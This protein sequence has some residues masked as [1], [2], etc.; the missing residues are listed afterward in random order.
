MRARRGVLLEAAGA[1]LHAVIVLGACALLCCSAPPRHVAPTSAACA[2]VQSSRLSGSVHGTDGFPA[3]AALLSIDGIVQRVAVT[4]RNG[5]FVVDELPP[6]RYLV[7]ARNAAA[8]TAEEVLVLPGGAEAQLWLEQGATTRLRVLD[9]ESGHPITGAVVR[10]G[11]WK[12]ETDGDGDALVVGALPGLSVIDVSA[13]AHASERVSVTLARGGPAEAAII[14]RLGRGRAVS[15]VVEGIGPLR[16]VLVSRSNTGGNSEVTIGP[17]GKWQARVRDDAT[18]VLEVSNSFGHTRKE[19]LSRASI[20]PRWSMDGQ[21]TKTIELSGVV[22]GEPVWVRVVTARDT[23]EQ[24]AEGPHVRLCGR[25]DG[26]GILELVGRRGRRRLEI[27]DGRLPASTELRDA[28]IAGSLVDLE[29]VPISG[30]WIEVSSTDSPVGQKL[31]THANRDGTFQ[32]PV[33]SG[34]IY[35]IRA[36]YPG[37]SRDRQFSELRVTS[38]DRLKLVVPVPGSIR[39]RLIL[40]GLPVSS[41]AVAVSRPTLGMLGRP[42]VSRVVNTRGAFE[43][44]GLEPGPWTLIV[45]GPGFAR[46][47]R[48]IDV[49]SGV[50]DLGDLEVD[51]GLTLRGQVRTADGPNANATV[52]VRPRDAV[53]SY[54][55]WTDPAVARLHGIATTRTDTSGQFMIDIDDRTDLV[56]QAWAADRATGSSAIP[57]P[58]ASTID[59]WLS[60]TATIHGQ[61]VG[62]SALSGRTALIELRGSRRNAEYVVTAMDGTFESRGLVPDRYDVRVISLPDRF[63]IRTAAVSVRPPDLTGEISLGQ[64]PGYDVTLDRTQGCGPASITIDGDEIG[65]LLPCGVTSLRLRGGPHRVCVAGRCRTFTVHART[66]IRLGS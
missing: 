14:V 51:R 25:V 13:P 24:T 31:H 60:P 6:G 62:W 18:Y 17:D 15:G 3:A 50:H 66:R 58:R 22:D 49:T 48:R 45:S 5:R 33:E 8:S 43:L 2:K 56:V 10:Y 28:V 53:D 27:P 32:V 47:V 57:I 11:A 44:T 55:G 64:E 7:A 21:E 35:M 59:L 46:R 42:I 19:E 36:G 16:A 54:A 1:G 30:G 40:D 39:G 9:E 23:Y 20:Q 61:I 4:D 26:E 41:F 29:G 65:G 37:Q 52:L 38:G 63:V 12:V 34:A